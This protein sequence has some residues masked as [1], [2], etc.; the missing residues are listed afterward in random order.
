MQNPDDSLKQ[1]CPQKIDDPSANQ[2]QDTTFNITWKCNQLTKDKGRKLYTQGKLKSLQ[3][4]GKYEGLY[5]V[6]NITKRTIFTGKSLK[7][8]S[9][10][11][12]M[13]QNEYVIS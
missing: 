7:F 4:E 3:G 5:Q 1:E 11:M 13:I 8:I 6:Y 10:F 2:T 9:C 12:L